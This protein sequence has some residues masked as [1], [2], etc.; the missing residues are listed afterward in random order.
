MINKFRLILSIFFS[1]LATTTTTTASNQTSCTFPC[2]CAGIASYTLWQVHTSTS[3]Y[4]TIST[5]SCNFSRTPLYFTSMAGTGSH[6][7]L[8]GYGAIYSSSNNSFTIY[9]QNVFSWSSTTMTSLANSNVWNVNWFGL[10][11]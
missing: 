1:F 6:Y 3:L 4:M 7:G 11:Y 2:L 10:Y 8:T 5:S 9:I